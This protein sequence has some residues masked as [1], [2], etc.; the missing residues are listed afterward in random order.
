MAEYML[1]YGMGRRVSVAET[2]TIL[3]KCEEEGLVHSVENHD[4]KLGTL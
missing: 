3:A 1:E 2:L 4:G